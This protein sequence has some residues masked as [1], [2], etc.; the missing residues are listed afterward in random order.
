M[1]YVHAVA[2][3]GSPFKDL[4]GN[5]VYIPTPKEVG[6]SSEVSSE[7]E[8]STWD[9]MT[10]DQKKHYQDCIFEC[11]R[12]YFEAVKVTR[13]K[14]IV[15]GSPPVLMTPEEVESMKTN[16]M[17]DKMPLDDMVNKAVHNAFL[18]Q[19]G[20]LVNSL[21]NLIKKVGD[22]FIHMEP[23]YVGPTIVPP[24]A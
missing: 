1:A 11:Q 17:P 6:K 12:K 4:E 14:E 18:T 2:D 20:V 21:Q 24:D 3:D 15:K 9:K 22:G 10:L 16:K 8:L 13:G 5:L 7:N 23:G 19:S